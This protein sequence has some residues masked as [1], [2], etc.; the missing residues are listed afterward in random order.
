MPKYI[1]PTTD[2]SVLLP[3]IVKDAPP[4]AVIETYTASMYDLVLKELHAAGRSDIEVR[5]LNRESPKGVAPVAGTD[6]Q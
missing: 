4:G 1:L 5:L 3:T 6:Q 2:W